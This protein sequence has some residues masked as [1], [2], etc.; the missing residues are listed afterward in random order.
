MSK[1]TIVLVPGA[2]HT[3]DSYPDVVTILSKHGYAT[4]GLPLPSV[5]AIPPHKD[6]TDD[7]GG[8]RSCLTKL[9]TEEKEVVLVVHSYSG[10]PGQQALERLSKNER[11]RKGLKGG[12]VRYV[13]IN[14]V[15]LPEGYPLISKGDYLK[16]PKWMKVDIQVRHLKSS[17][18]PT[19][20]YLKICLASLMFF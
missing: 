4:I 3:P 7:L 17:I 1:P 15:I 8:I 11:M 13:G 16:F 20:Q 12:V 10:L 9:V 6:F 14:G 19:Y 18:A 2:W 5:G